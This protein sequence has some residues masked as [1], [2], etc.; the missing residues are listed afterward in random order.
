MCLDT[1][2]SY[3]YFVEKITLLYNTCFPVIDDK[4]KQNKCRKP[5]ISTG[6]LRSISKKNRLY[7]MYLRKLS[8]SY[9]L[10]YTVYKINLL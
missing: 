7:K 6:I 5:W 2:A 10:K 1:N 8:E 9:R 3:D 4:L